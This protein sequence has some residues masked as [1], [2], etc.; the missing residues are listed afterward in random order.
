MFSGRLC[1]S[2]CLTI[3][4]LIAREYESHLS[5]KSQILTVLMLSASW[6]LSNR[7][8]KF[9]FES[10]VR[11]NNNRDAKNSSSRLSL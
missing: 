2:F 6:L 9:K 3:K 1:V 5:G 11:R 10:Y 4:I 7:S 8:S